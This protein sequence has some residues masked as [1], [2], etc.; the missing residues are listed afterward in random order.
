MESIA[1]S[2]SPDHTTT[3]AA[4]ERSEAGTGSA[5][6]RL[7]GVWQLTLHGDEPRVSLPVTVQRLLAFLALTGP[8]LR[9]VVAGTLWTDASESHAH[10]CLRTALWRLHRSG[11]GHFVE[12]QGDALV[13]GTDINVDVHEFLAWASTVVRHQLCPRGELLLGSPHRAGELLPGWYDD[14]VLMERERLRQL[15]LYALEALAERLILVNRC[16]EALMAGLE[17]VA[18]EPLR[19]SAHRLV[20]RVHLADG[21]VAEALRHFESYG[22]MMR[23]ELDMPASEGMAELI[24]PY[25]VRTY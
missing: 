4:E 16:G 14:W 8:Q 10:G 12:V 23:R 3:T 5:R 20:V 15:R 19:E 25:G 13:L 18:L 17:A 21:N 9:A 2:A 22:Q 11:R 24:R 7:F 6:L 1:T